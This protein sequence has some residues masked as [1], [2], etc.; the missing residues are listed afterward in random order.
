MAAFHLGLLVD[1]LGLGP[2]ESRERRPVA[3]I[4]A[5][6]NV[7]ARGNVLSAKLPPGASGL[8]RSVV[9]IPQPFESKPRSPGW[10]VTTW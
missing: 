9:Q 6:G 10:I 2:A 7:R 4:G 8:V 3:A 1:D 5:A